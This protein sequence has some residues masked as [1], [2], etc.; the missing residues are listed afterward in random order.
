VELIDRF[1]LLPES[2]QHLFALAEL[3]LRVAALGIRKLEA[4]A[5]G[6]RMVF[7]PRTTVDPARILPLIQQ[8]ARQY[9]LEGG[10][11]LRFTLP[12]AEP[13]DRLTQVNALLDH[14]VSGTQN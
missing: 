5:A 3:K 12:M 9:R 11:T 14:L 13:Q 10:D 1:G 8:Q 2:A 4:G 7:G 6:G